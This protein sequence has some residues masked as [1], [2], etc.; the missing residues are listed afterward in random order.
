MSSYYFF[1]KSSHPCS[2]F[3]TVGS[4]RVTVKVSGV[5]GSFS[6]SNSETHFMMLK[7]AAFNDLPSLAAI[8]AAKTPKEARALGREVKNYDERVWSGDVDD[9]GLTL[10]ERCMDVALQRK[11]EVCIPYLDVIRAQVERGTKF[12]ETSHWDAKWGT[13]MT[14]EKTRQTSPERW[15]TNLLGKAHDRVAARYAAT[16]RQSD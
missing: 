5:T 1:A 11:L 7:A 9:E 13:G 4:Y 12:V 8:A 3:F 10:A 15:G 2:N 14:E 16:S 6:I